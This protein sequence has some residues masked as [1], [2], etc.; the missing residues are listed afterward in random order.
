MIKALVGDVVAL[1][2]FSLLSYRVNKP[3]TVNSEK[4]AEHLFDNIKYKLTFSFCQV[5][6]TRRK[7]LPKSAQTR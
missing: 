6:V 4:F 3:K 7:I 5:L 2:V 1:Y